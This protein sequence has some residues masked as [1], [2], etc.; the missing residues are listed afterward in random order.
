MTQLFQ[1]ISENL[2]FV[3]MCALITAVLWG[4]SKL[5]QRWLSLHAVTPARRVSIVG[6]CAAIEIGRAHV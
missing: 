4:G 6:I 5:S 3:G 2:S 1:E